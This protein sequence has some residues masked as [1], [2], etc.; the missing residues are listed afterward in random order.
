MFTA[1]LV[2]ILRLLT[3]YPNGY[4]NSHDRP[5]VKWDIRDGK[6]TLQ[7]LHIRFDRDGEKDLS[8]RL[9]GAKDCGPKG[10][11]LESLP[12]SGSERIEDR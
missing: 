5:T 12:L 6:G 10:K 4:D 1:S 2:R 9:P 11:K 3:H 7:A 8:R